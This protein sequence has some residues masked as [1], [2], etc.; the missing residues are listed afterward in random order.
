MNVAFKKLHPDTDLKVTSGSSG[1]FAT[2][3][4]NGAPYDVF[5]SADVS[6]PRDLVKAGLADEASLTTYAMGKIVLWTTRPDAVDVSRGLAV[7]Q[8]PGI[9]KK[10]AVANPDHAPYGRAAKE[11]VAA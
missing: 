5:L 7:L 3:I 2:Q 6:F 10:L 11:G 4:K 8:D 1:N 9:V